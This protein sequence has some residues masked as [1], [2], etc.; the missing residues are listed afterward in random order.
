MY[1]ADR[2]Y[3]ILDPASIDLWERYTGEF[4]ALPPGSFTEWLAKQDFEVQARRICVTKTDEFWATKRADDLHGRAFDSAMA[5]ISEE[6]LAELR[7]LPLETE[8]DRTTMDAFVPLAE[9]WIDLYRQLA[10]GKDPTGE[11][12]FF[13]RRDLQLAMWELIDGCLITGQPM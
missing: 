9:Q 4:V 5:E 2:R 12:V 10:L 7:A 11:A 8:A 3:P 1:D 6:T 13:Q